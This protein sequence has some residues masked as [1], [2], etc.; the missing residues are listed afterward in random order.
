M[1]KK[2]KSVHNTEVLYAFY[3]QEFKEMRNQS[4]LGKK[5]VYEQC[6]KLSDLGYLPQGYFPWTKVAFAS[7]YRENYHRSCPDTI[8]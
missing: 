6:G 8:N 7:W 4:G 5:K 1:T 3:V 2:K